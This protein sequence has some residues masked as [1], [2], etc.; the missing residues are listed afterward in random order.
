M[1]FKRA[2]PPSFLIFLN[3][4]ACLHLQMPLISARFVAFAQ[5]GRRNSK[6]KADWFTIIKKCADNKQ[7][8]ENAGGRWFHALAVENVPGVSSQIPSTNCKAPG[9]YFIF[10]SPAMLPVL[11]QRSRSSF[12]DYRWKGIH[13][14]HEPVPPHK[15]TAVQK[16]LRSESLW[17]KSLRRW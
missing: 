7:K 1:L 14:L 16:P 11:L 17:R 12:P 4:S 13:W 10:S 15:G 6:M 3:S 2:F 5:A 9:D 8:N